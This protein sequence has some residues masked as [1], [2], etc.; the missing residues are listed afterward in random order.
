MS[1]KMVPKII[2]EG[3][4][5]THKTDV[6]FALNRHPS[7]YD[8]L[9]I[10]IKEQKE[11]SKFVEKS[12]LKSVEIDVSDGDIDSICDDICDWYEETDGIYLSE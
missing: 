2:L 1:K 4:R 11:F 3:T 9:S 7:Q 8:D 12:L 10:F 6:A 5:M